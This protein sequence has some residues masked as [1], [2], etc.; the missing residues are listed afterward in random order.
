MQLILFKNDDWVK[1]LTTYSVGASVMLIK[2]I[3]NESI[4]C[5]L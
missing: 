1:Y 3:A 4:P 5:D 2:S